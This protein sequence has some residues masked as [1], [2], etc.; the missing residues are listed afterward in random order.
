MPSLP[1]RGSER[2]VWA[3]AG[4]RSAHKGSFVPRA[5]PL[6]SQGFVRGSPVTSGGGTLRDRGA[7]QGGRS[8]AES[9]RHSVL[10]TGTQRGDTQLSGTR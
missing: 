2:G 10:G 4:P 8:S 5:P 9:R 3:A 7:E 6:L 1:L